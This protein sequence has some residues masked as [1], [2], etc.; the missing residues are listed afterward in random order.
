[1]KTAR[2]WGRE[3]G[4]SGKSVAVHVLVVSVCVYLDFTGVLG[5]VDEVKG[6]FDGLPERDHAVIPQ[7]Q[8]LTHTENKTVD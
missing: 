6:L 7:H 3:G 1:M 2:G 8:N 5:V 4:L